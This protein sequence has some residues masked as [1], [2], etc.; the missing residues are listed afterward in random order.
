M[1]IDLYSACISARVT[2]VYNYLANWEGNGIINQ[3]Q[4]YFSQKQNLD[5]YAVN[6]VTENR[7][8][9][10]HSTVINTFRFNYIK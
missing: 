1:Q 8:V 4:T 5:F 9:Q 2:N 7:N 10:S 3:T 6:L